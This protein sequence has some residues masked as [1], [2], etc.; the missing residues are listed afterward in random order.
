MLLLNAADTPIMLN[1]LVARIRQLFRKTLKKVH[2]MVLADRKVA[3]TLKISEGSVF[4]ILHEHFSMRKSSVR[5]GYDHKQ[6]R[7][8]DSERCLKLF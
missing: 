4:T 6:Q 3:D 1:A 8:D 5:N 7:V 2:K